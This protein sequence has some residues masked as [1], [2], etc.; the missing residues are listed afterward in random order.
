M[1]NFWLRVRVWTKVT[2]IVAVAVY[3][4]VFASIN[5]DEPVKLWIFYNR[6]YE[7]SVLMLV[8]MCFGIGV[9]GTLLARTTFKTVRQVREL[10][11]K[12]RVI[13]MQRENADMKAKA[14]MLQTRSEPVLTAKPVERAPERVVD[15]APTLA[16]ASGGDLK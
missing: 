7:G 14:S 12:G 1:S 8:L 5:S 9:V 2:L 15:P 10:R 13:K 16:D 11:E 6:R 4:L 3:A